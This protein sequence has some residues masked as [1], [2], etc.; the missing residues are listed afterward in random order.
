VSRKR[1][2][3]SDYSCSVRRAVRGPAAASNPNGMICVSFPLRLR[4]RSTP[5]TRPESGT[6]TIEWHLSNVECNRALAG[7]S[8]PVRSLS[9]GSPFASPGRCW[10]TGDGLAGA[11]GIV[12]QHRNGDV[13]D[14]KENADIS[15]ES[16]TSCA[17]TARAGKPR[18]GLAAFL[19]GVLGVRLFMGGSEDL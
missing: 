12:T 8:N 18:C 17:P 14:A 13:A 10:R 11:T 4:R 16:A 9:R 5:H 3:V 1:L 15:T 7:P 2:R 19:G 6:A